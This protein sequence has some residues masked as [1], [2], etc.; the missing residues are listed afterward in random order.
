[1]VQIVI[2]YLPH[3]PKK[4]K[5]KKNTQSSA[6]WLMQSKCTTNRSWFNFFKFVFRFVYLYHYPNEEAGFDS[7]IVFAKACF[8]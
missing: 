7:R 2:K 1:M 3:K 4:N 5:K 6:E 8:W